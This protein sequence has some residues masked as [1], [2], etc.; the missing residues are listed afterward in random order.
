VKEEA[1]KMVVGNGKGHK[2]ATER[3]PAA[4]LEDS[5]A[6]NL[7]FVQ[8]VCPSYS[9]A[10]AG[11]AYALKRAGI[12][13]GIKPP[14]GIAPDCVV[15][16]AQDAEHLSEAIENIL[17]ASTDQTSV[18]CPIL[19]FA[20]Q[21]DWKLAEASLRGGARG[22]IHAMMRPEQILR[23][24]SV[25]SKGEIVAPRGLLEFLLADESS[26]G[27][28]D[29]LSARQLQILELV[30]EGCSNPQISRR[31]FL[32]E[33]TI[34]QH[35]GA[36]FKILGVKNRT[37]AVKVMRRAGWRGVANVRPT[38]PPSLSNTTRFSTN[39]KPGSPGS[40]KVS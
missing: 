27:H 21:N 9:V 23:A 7:E 8:V 30:A 33:S 14:P 15:L 11:L 5:A 32:A 24:L 39:L 29:D 19:I 28:L 22:F 25:A 12:Q 16:C 2:V 26:V 31:L 38:T 6:V 34:K 18:D 4:R 36:A 20:P 37:Q 3:R 35:L 17:K 10:T 40:E 1:K 13:H